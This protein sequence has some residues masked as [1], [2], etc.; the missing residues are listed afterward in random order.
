MS[1][2]AR[3]CA[4]NAFCRPE[5]ASGVSDL[6][7]TSASSC[8]VG[9][10]CGACPGTDDAF[11]SDLLNSEVNSSIRSAA[12]FGEASENKSATLGAENVI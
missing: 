4:A 11:E 7:A 1:C 10:A 9:S 12:S 2:I 3:R 5:A 8:A 6:F